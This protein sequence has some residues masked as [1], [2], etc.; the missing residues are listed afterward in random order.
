MT[1]EQGRVVVIGA[2]FA[3]LAVA[4]GLLGSG[5][6]V[7]VIDKRNFHLFQPLLY[8]VA[9]GGLSPANIATPVRSLFRGDPRFHVRMGEVTAIDLQAR[10]VLLAGEETPI[11]FDTLIVATGMHTQYFGNDGWAELAPGLKTIE[12]ALDIRTRVLSAFE[13]AETETDPAKRARDLTFAV[14]GGGPTGVELAGAIAEIA[15]YTLKGEY[16]SYDPEN[17]RVFLLEGSKTI[18]PMYDE[19]LRDRARTDLAKLGVTVRENT[20][21]TN[22]TADGVT[23]KVD[24]QEE[25]IEAGT[26]VWATGVAAS[27]L[28]RMLGEAA[29][30][31]VDRSGRVE[32]TPVLTLPGYDNVYVLGDMA[33]TKDEAGN[34]LPA[35]ASV[36]LQQGKY[37]ARVLRAQMTDKP[38]PEPFRYIDRGTMATIGRAAAIADLRGLRLTGFIGWLS[39]LFVHLILLIEFRN[40]LMVLITWAWGFFTRNRFARLITDEG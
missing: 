12:D 14:V 9:T 13:R 33:H 37:V 22:I 16:R 18:L 5:A 39:W 31:T 8:Q 2:G 1:G 21:V 27:P 25:V 10:H 17:T 34:P 32:V 24:G 28:A 29:G 35:L 6:H 38:A 3:G 15:H 30:V 20:L 19:M 4:K 7:T 36:A 40:R 11:P 23:V 26:V